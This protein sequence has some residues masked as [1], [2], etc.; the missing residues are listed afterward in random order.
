[1]LGSASG[2]ESTLTRRLSTEPNMLRLAVSQGAIGCFHV[3]SGNSGSP[4]MP[5]WRALPRDVGENTSSR[6]GEMLD[7]ALDSVALAVGFLRL[8]LVV[9]GCRALE[10]IHAHAKDRIGMGWVQPDG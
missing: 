10:P 3:C 8:D 6:R 4:E 7:R 9:V 1:M 2:R 5:V